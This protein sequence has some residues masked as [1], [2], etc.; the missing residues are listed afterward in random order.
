MKYDIEAVKRKMLI[1]YPFFGSVTANVDYKETVEIDTMAT[2]GETIYYNR[3]YVETLDQSEQ[4][5]VF[6]HEVCHIAFNH[7]MK[8]DG[9]VPKIWNMATDAV[10]N[11]WLKK[12]KLTMPQYGVN[13]EDAINYDSEELYEKL[14]EEQTKNQQ[15]KKNTEDWQSQE[16]QT[17]E[18]EEQDVGHDTHRMWP[19][20][21][22]K[23]KQ[24][25]KTE[26]S[27][28]Q[29]QNDEE[30]NVVRQKQKELEKLGESESFSKNRELK[31]RNLE[32]LKR[33]I[34]ESSL[35]AGT[36]TNGETRSL[37]NIGA[38]KPLIDW[39]YILRETINYEVDWSYKN[40]TIEDGVVTPYLE[41]QQV[42][43]TEILL[44]T[45]ESVSTALLKNF[46]RECKNIVQYSK[47]EVGCFDTRFY[48]FHEIR[49]EEDIEKMDYQGR[50]GTDFNVAV[51]A[52]S[53]RVE[54]KIIFTDGQAP[55]PEMTIDAIWIVY[56]GKKIKPRGGRVIHITD[57]QLK[58]LQFGEKSNE[59]NENKNKLK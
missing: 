2:D 11:Q 23:R 38:S 52:F 28:E 34:I 17:E 25:E 45:S 6:A 53:R 49:T 37:E 46:V 29:K 51:E 40:A 55:M 31:K 42:P 13:I 27:G 21:V 26:N 50:G 19:E 5:F 41:E 8:S 43:K 59:L 20:A 47:V 33:E 1:K 7:I 18:K 24:E 32:E 48:G 15:T 58:K 57:E 56:G 16:Q 3:K 12:D 36:K 54:N 14:L 22:K 4:I 39:R 9:K 35:Q 10:I 44:D 30:E